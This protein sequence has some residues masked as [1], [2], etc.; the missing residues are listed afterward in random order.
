M[1]N[2]VIL[3][4]NAPLTEDYRAWIDESAF[5]VRFN[6]PQN[7]SA[8]TGA[9]CNALCL[10][11]HGD[12]ARRFAKYRMIRGLPCLQP[13]TEIWFPRPRTIRA[14]TCLFNHPSRRIRRRQDYSR[15]IVARN[16]LNR[17]H[18]VFFSESLWTRSFGALSLD[19]REELL[20]PSTGFLALMYCLDRFP[21]S[22]YRIHLL[23]FTF[24]GSAAHPWELEK[25]AVQRM[26]GRGHVVET[27]ASDPPRMNQ[28]AAHA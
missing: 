27:V 7:T 4:A 11:N 1:K 19:P 24:Q 15:H 8:T 3:I 16:D 25:Q 26:S 17:H 14:F 6:V 10:T 28:L 18:Q 2:D 9:R 22:F 5:V 13:T 23:G 12:P 21:T 20:T